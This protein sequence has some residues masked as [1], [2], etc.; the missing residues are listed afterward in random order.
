M[1]Q[2]FEFWEATGLL[3]KPGFVTKQHIV[4]LLNDGAEY[5]NRNKHLVSKRV[6]SLFFPCIRRLCDF[7]TLDFHSLSIIID[8]TTVNEDEFYTAMDAE[9]E[10]CI[11][12]EKKYRDKFINS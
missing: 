9:A 10:A 11:E 12:A 5:L 2:S 7:E 8:N 1:A 6:R 3:E 4:D